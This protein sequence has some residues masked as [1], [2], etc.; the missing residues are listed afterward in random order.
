MRTLKIFALGTVATGIVAYAV[1][2]AVA[3]AAQ[4]DERSLLVAVGP[5]VI[6]SVAVHG[7][8]TATT[9]G[10]GIVLIALAGGL[11]NLFAG[12]LLRRRL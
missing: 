5:V 2:A 3:L 8:T 10:V 11:L 6:V 12:Q 7:A 1:V 4:A 9:F